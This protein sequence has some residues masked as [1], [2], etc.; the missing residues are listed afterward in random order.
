MA[1]F[2]ALEALKRYF[3]DSPTFRIDIPFTAVP[4]RH[5]CWTLLTSVFGWT[6]RSNHP[7]IYTP[8]TR[9]R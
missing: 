8:Y 3:R 9:W 2:P 4:R 5:Q 1:T 7:L 6:W